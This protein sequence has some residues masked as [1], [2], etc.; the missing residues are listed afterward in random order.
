LANRSPRMV[1]RQLVAPG[2]FEWRRPGHTTGHRTAL[3]GQ[4]SIRR[5]LPRVACVGLNPCLLPGE[6]SGETVLRGR[7]TPF[8][9]GCLQIATSMVASALTLA[10]PL[11]GRHRACPL[12][13][14]DADVLRQGGIDPSAFVQYNMSRWAPSFE[15]VLR[16]HR[17][18]LMRS[19]ADAP[20]RRSWIPRQICDPL[21]RSPEV[22]EFRTL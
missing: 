15:R 6:P 5:G 22:A 2:A 17:R 14:A 3:L 13:F 21:R 20:T 1:G 16:A 10:L 18:T 8:Q 19:L 4:R 9:D 7:A 11:G 12:A